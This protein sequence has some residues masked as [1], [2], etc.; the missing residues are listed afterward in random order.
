MHAQKSS[1]KLIDT[2]VH[3]KY[4]ILTVTNNWFKKNK[5]S[6]SVGNYV[7]WH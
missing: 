6:L 3:S 4:L 1:L 7:D 2:D 5:A